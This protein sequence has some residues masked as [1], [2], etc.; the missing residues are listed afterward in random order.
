MLSK[1][2]ILLVEDDETASFLM[3]TFLEDSGF[4]VQAVFTITDG[5][6]YLQNN[7]YDLLLLDL[8]LP[9]FSG[10]DL[11]SKI[12]TTIAIPTIIITAYNDTNLIVKAF[13][14]GAHDYLVKPVNFVELEARVWG[15]LGRYNNI[16]INIEDNSLF[17]IRNTQIFFKDKLLTLTALEFEILSFFINHI[18]QTISREI[19]IEKISAL[20]SPRLLDNHIKNIRKK[21]E[22]DSDKPQHLKTLYGVG[23]ILKQ[24]I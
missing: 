12:K 5:I 11:L 2:K 19:L 20:K 4:F 1:T 14:Y 15:L 13:K 3:K 8:N 23:Y 22:I 7:D 18:E 10:F 6:A 17:Q 24:E 21:M 16:K 9:D